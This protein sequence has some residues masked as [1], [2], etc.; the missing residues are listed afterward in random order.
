MPHMQLADVANSCQVPAATLISNSTD[1][2]TDH[3]ECWE[4]AIASRVHGAKGVNVL[5]HGTCTYAL[6]SGA[7]VPLISVNT[8]K[9]GSSANPYFLCITVCYSDLLFMLASWGWLYSSM[10]QTLC[11][12]SNLL[13][14]FIG[15]ALRLTCIIIGTA[16]TVELAQASEKLPDSRKVG[17]IS[18]CICW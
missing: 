1:S 4:C 12:V 9:T 13:C 6:F 7:L 15:T 10:N 2:R 14:A 5:T 3:S 11:S 16:V 8:F 18:M 17:G